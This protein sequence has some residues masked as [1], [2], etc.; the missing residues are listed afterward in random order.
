[1]TE[2]QSM[3]PKT[4][5]RQILFLWFVL[6]CVYFEHT[7]ADTS[8]FRPKHVYSWRLSFAGFITG[9]PNTHYSQSL[10]LSSPHPLMKRWQPECLTDRYNS[11]YDL[12]YKDHC[13]CSRVWFCLLL[14]QPAVLQP[15]TVKH[16]STTAHA[17]NLPRQTSIN[18]CYLKGQYPK[19]QICFLV[20]KHQ[21]T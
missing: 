6:E 17:D 3:L 20:D 4:S 10:P 21:L 14:F 1:M 19:R 15:L 18:V 8:A 5:S 7:C 2:M 13:N 12:S 9:K 16:T 11:T